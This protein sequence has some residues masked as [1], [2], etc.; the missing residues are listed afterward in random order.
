MDQQK[1]VWSDR[2]K[3]GVEVIDRE[4]R[5]LFSI[6]NKLFTYKG[7][8]DEKSRWAYQEGIKFFKGHAM[9]HFAE[10]EMYMASIGYEGYETHRRLHDIFR[11]KTLPEIEKELMLTQ[12]SPE[13][14]E[15][16]LGVCAGWL[17]G[18]T[19]TED[20]AIT[21]GVSSRWV[22]LLPEEEQALLQKTLLQLLKEVF[23]LDARVL[24]ESYSGE[25]FGNGIYYRLLY[26]SDKGE[27]W[28]FFLIFEEKLLVET[29][30][31]IVDGDADKVNVMMMN[32]TR[33]IARQFVE[34]ILEHFPTEGQVEL[35]EENLLNYKKFDRMFERQNLQSSLLFD[36]GKGYFAYCMLAPHLL[37][38]TASSPAIRAEN[39]M[40]EILKYLE[41]NKE[42]NDNSGKKKILVVDD[43]S[44]ILKAMTDLLEP[45]YEVQTA[46]SGIA[47]IRS[48]TLDK[49]D[50]VLLDYEMPV[51]TG[52][53]VLEM[54]RAEEAFVD[55]PVIFLTGRVDKERIQKILP[56]KPAGYLLKTIQPHEIRAAIEEFFRKRG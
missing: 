27:K 52:Q 16:F 9:K 15:H 24:S 47:A 2:Y 51:C 13:A 40:T 7:D 8:N 17:I 43:S 4:H 50:L 5:K 33:Y 44:V 3:I 56:L 48:M 14:V 19:M 31:S 25:K 18:H 11:K 38:D 26:G 55:T 37:G 49:P 36:T 29:V 30:G 42:E 53:Q 10:E 32:A 35:K 1:F 12:Y 54:I 34:R 6:M 20:R 46:N 39:A 22:D 21:G 41:E 45:D 28:E 23:Q